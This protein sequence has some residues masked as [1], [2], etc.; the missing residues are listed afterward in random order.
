MLG[1]RLSSEDEAKLDRYA[2]DVRRPKS[3]VARDWILERLE[4]ESTDTLMEREAKLLARHY[5]PEEDIE[6]D[7]DD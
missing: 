3:A 5:R 1:I 4:R 2:R 7:W 6:A